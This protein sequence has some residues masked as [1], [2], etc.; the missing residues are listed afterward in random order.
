[1]QQMSPRRSRGGILMEMYRTSDGCEVLI[2]EIPA[3]D[4]HAHRLFCA[5]LAGRSLDHFVR[6]AADR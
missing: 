5:G 6:D 1:M 2:P 4:E 3:W